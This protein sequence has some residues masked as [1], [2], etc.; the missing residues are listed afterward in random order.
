MEPKW[1][2]FEEAWEYALATIFEGAEL[3]IAGERDVMLCNGFP[4]V[5]RLTYRRLM[6]K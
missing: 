1:L 2:S 6:A 3:E 5:D 4:R